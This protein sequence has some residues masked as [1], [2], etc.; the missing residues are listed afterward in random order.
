LIR[1][2]ALLVL[3]TI[4]T[5]GFHTLIP[6]HWL[7]FVLVARSQGW[8]TRRT[9]ALTAASASLHVCLSIALGLG[10][11]LLGRGAEA[12]V[13]VGESISR[14]SALFLIIFGTLYAGWFLIKGGHQHSFGMHPHHSPVPAHAAATPHP[15]DLGL[16]V[17]HQE[18]LRSPGNGFRTGGISLALI[19]GFNPCVLVIPYIYLAGTMGP[20]ILALVA[21]AFAVSTV[22]CMVGIV[23]VGLK[24]TARLESPFL[25]RFGEAV[26]GA[27][28][29][30]TGLVVMLSGG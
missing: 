17:V 15:H 2:V 11:H 9:V 10:A 28:I 13:G 22:V 7:P 20:S 21:A 29:A 24:G 1:P 18:S 26:S 27:L 5:A 8:G 19:V 30:V 16:G 6:D 14:I 23:L 3:T 25:M 12:A 4:V